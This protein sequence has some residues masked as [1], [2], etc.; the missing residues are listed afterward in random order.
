MGGGSHYR[1]PFSESLPLFI[2]VKIAVPSIILAAELPKNLLLGFSV[3]STLIL[4]PG[5]M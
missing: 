1:S 3:P 2:M 5:T 4:C